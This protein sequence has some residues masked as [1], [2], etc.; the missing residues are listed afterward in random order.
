ML[1][2][3][4]DYIVIGAGSSG[5]GLTAEL[6]EAGKSVLL[7]EAGGRDCSPFIKIPAGQIKAITKY[8]W[9]YVSEADASRNGAAA[10][11]ARGRVL[12][13]SSSVNGTMY[14]RGV[15]SDYD[16]W[17]I[18][19]WSWNDVLPI[20]QDFEA[21]DQP[22]VLRGH[23]G[24]LSIRT[25][26]RPHRLTQAFV[27]A[28]RTLGLPF[29]PD[30][31][32]ESQEGVGF[33]QLTQRRGFRCS[34]ADAFLKPVLHKR[35]LTLIVEALVTR[36]EFSG[37]RAVA[38]HFEKAGMSRR[39]GARNVVLCGGVIN[40]PQLLMLSGIGPARELTDKQIEVVLDLPAVGDNLQEQPLI[41]PL[42][43][44]RIPSYNLTNGL[45]QKVG[46]AAKYLFH[47][48]GPI[49]NLFEAAAF[50]R[51]SP[52]LALPDIQVI[53]SAL[54][55]GK[56]ADGDYFMEDTPS[57][58]AHVML[59]YPESR[60]RIRLRSKDPGNPPV[61]EC[62]LLDA[63]N[64]VKKLVAGLRVIRRIMRA[65]P[66]REWVSSEVLPGENAQSDASLEEYVR[67][68]T[69]VS[70]HPI[71]SCRMGVGPDAVVGPDLRIRGLENLWI[72]D[73]SVVPSYPSANMNAV[74]IMVGRKL[75][76]E[77]A[78]GGG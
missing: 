24:P 63:H 7:L 51:S 22:G 17:G 8:D 78:T 15:P 9:G 41:S 25:V 27:D 3:Q 38:V 76:R 10:H 48:E 77:L 64:D 35:N 11:W 32:G 73:A 37:H 53:F 59:S 44:T 26:R 49:A 72:A 52:S 4:W 50:L 31:N 1:V 60:G 36:I 40:S 33:A 57:V 29:N 13:G 68:H 2:G 56:K 61:I 54:G 23:G 20:F 30:Y 62:P 39:V 5:C 45:G 71:G 74:C 18:P 65:G 6:V 12:G 43:R 46:Y 58:M 55:Y 14:T 66:L 34:A 42:Y 47:G 21:S 75:G 28:A 69:S 16:G 19:G 70:F 67:K